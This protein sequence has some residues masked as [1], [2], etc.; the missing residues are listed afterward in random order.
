MKNLKTWGITL[1]IFGLLT[2]SISNAQTSDHTLSLIK[3]LQDQVALLQ[4]K[5]NELIA[6]QDLTN[7]RLGMA[8]VATALPATTTSKLIEGSISTS[9]VITDTQVI[10]ST[11]TIR[12]GIPDTA[13]ES[14]PIQEY[15]NDK[16]KRLTLMRLLNVSSLSIPACDIGKG[17]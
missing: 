13:S 17:G 15:C 9:T 14:K 2:P 8:S 4:S 3:S 11:T 16:N 1:L 5:L 6:K 10:F 12:G 7:L